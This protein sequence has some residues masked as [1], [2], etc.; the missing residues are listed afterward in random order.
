MS[1]IIEIGHHHWLMGYECHGPSFFNG[2]L[3]FGEYGLVWLHGPIKA[4]KAGE[5]VINKF[6]Q[7]E[8][9]AL[10]FNIA[11]HTFSIN[12]WSQ[13]A[14]EQYGHCLLEL[15]YKDNHDDQKM[16]PVKVP[17]RFYLRP[18]NPPNG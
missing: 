16:N 10:D 7:T 11:R 8:L 3:V 9:L 1:D 14:K 4:E 17:F 13:D 12:P 6:P 5:Y 15:Y 18:Y 2:I